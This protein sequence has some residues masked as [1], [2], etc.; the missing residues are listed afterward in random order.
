LIYATIIP[1]FFIFILIGIANIGRII[2]K[3]L[4]KDLD[5]L[6]L[7]ITYGISFLAFFIGL[8]L[9][10]N[11]YNVKFII[12]LLISSFLLKIFQL[13]L[14]K[15]KALINKKELIVK[16]LILLSFLISVKSLYFS[17]DDISGYFFTITKYINGKIYIKENN[18][19]KISR[20]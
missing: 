17:V 15:I 14:N 4:L 8:L 3:Y 20:Y 16:I 1:F 18:I 5:K 12:F 9:C 10:L 19:N 11:I 6:Y 13:N 7:N 2:N